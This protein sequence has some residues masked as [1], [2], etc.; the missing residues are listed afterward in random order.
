MVPLWQPSLEGAV[1]IEGLGLEDGF[2][3][4][5][6]CLWLKV[7]GLVG[8]WSSHPQGPDYLARTRQRPAGMSAS[9]K[10]RA[11]CRVCAVGGGVGPQSGEGWGSGLENKE[12]LGA[13]L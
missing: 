6:S 1:T 8:E 2:E 11:N 13:G 3:G 9:C 4:E 12:W 5:R 10:W 7:L